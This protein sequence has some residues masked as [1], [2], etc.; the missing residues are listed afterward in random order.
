MNRTLYLI[1][2]VLLAGI[3]ISAPE[4]AHAETCSFT[5]NLELGYQGEEVRCLQRYLNSTGFV[6]ATEGVGS[7]GQ[8]TSLYREKTVDAVRRWQTAYG[9][10]PATGTFGPLS[11]AK[12]LSLVGTTAPTTPT[13]P[14]PVPT[15]SSSAQAKART[16]IQSA[17]SSIEDVEDKVEQADDAGW[18]IDEAEDFL[19]DADGDLLNALYAF[20]DE[21]Y[22]DALVS[23]QSARD[24]ARKA[25]DSLT[26]GNDSENAED[27]LENAEEAIEDAWDDVIEAENDD[28]DVDEAEDLLE[29]AEDLLEEAEE[30]LD[31]EDYD[32][33]VELANDI[34]DLVEEALD[35]ID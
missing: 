23:G 34:D 16:A 30:A 13:T 11:Q 29:E 5:G 18:D 21:D 4:S 20:I 33:V 25:L 8:E 24:F 19:R 32:D 15:T 10:S 27:A 14:T 6:V 35:S 3:L 9:V 22:S 12:Y 7:S 1:P 28:K 31:D 2:I 17:I 26:T